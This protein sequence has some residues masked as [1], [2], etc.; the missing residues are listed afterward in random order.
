VSQA[1]R[2]A[3]CRVVRALARACGESFAAAAL[4]PVLA[5]HA[6]VLTAVCPTAAAAAA[7]DP[8]SS[9]LQVK[10]RR[11]KLKPRLCAHGSVLSRLALR[12]GAGRGL[13][14]KMHA[15]G[16][17]EAGAVPSSMPA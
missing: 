15:T 3:V 11:F 5:A 1:L 12:R 9:A 6:H 16:C 13:P 10:T 2:T 17:S 4:A 7:A 14:F 8:A